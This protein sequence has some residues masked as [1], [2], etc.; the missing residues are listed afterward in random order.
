MKYLWNTF[1]VTYNASFIGYEEILKFKNNDGSFR[2]FYS[3]T[4]STKA[5]VFLT[6]LAAK[7]LFR[8]KQYISSDEN[9]ITTAIKW[10]YGK[11]LE[12]GR[13]LVDAQDAYN[14]MLFFN[15]KES[16][17]IENSPAVLTSYVLSSVL[18]V[19]IKISETVLAKANECIV[20]Y[21]RNS[22]DQYLA[23]IGS[24]ALLLSNSENDEGR[25]ILD[26]LIKQFPINSERK[27]CTFRHVLDTL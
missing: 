14:F 18:E 19:G 20:D 26:N 13:F 25:R 5:S 23:A 12:N 1:L 11:Q 2:K 24:Y 16:L 8:S 7:N 27:Y 10:I 9:V 3:S 21:I 4:I 6:T 22:T 15:I 17:L